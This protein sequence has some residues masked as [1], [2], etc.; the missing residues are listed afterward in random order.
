M[1]ARV[2]CLGETVTEI[3]TDREVLT[4]LSFPEE[5][6]DEASD[7]PTSYGNVFDTRADHVTFGLYRVTRSCANIGQ[8]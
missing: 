3:D 2:E 8:I 6:L 1:I 4:N 7:G 5:V